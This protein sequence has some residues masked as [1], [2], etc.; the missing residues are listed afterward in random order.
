MKYKKV[1]IGIPTI[2][3][4][5]EYIEQ[6]NFNV[7]AEDIYNHY[8]DRK[9]LTLKNKPMCSLEAMVNSW[10]GVMLQRER[11]RIKNEKRKLA[12]TPKTKQD[13]VKP[14]KVKQPYVYMPYKEQLK[15]KR[16]FDFREHVFNCKGRKCEICGSTEFLQVHHLRYK[17]KHYAW[18]YKVH[19]MQV[20]CR[21]CHTKIHGIDLDKEYKSITN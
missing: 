19:D 20:L 16:W 18:E 5:Q 3:Q 14:K 4:I 9:W 13:K 6:K 8:K 2:K 15:D 1:E 10:N 7:V 12:R 11:T 21:R 17:K